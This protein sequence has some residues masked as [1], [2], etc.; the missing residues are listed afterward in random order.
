MESK[1][2]SDQQLL[3]EFVANDQ[4]QLASQEASDEI[5]SWIKEEKYGG[6]GQ[7]ALSAVEGAASAATFGLS[8]GVQE[9]LGV[10]MEDVQGRREE[11]PISY[12]AGQIAGLVGTSGLGSLPKGAG[13]AVEAAGTAAARALGMGEAT[14]LAKVGTQAAK[15]AVE[16]MLV[17]SGDEVS[18]MFSDDAPPTEA[19]QTA[20]LNIGL[21]G[22]IGGGLGAG[23]GAVSPL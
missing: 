8:T 3:N 16:N 20:L 21:S 7:Q 11:N 14:A 5:G 22:L 13:F 1:P 4:S 2:A 6:I 19:A 10:N 12:A 17:T 18:K 15:L 9:A 23:F